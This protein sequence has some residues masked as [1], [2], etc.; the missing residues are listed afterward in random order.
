MAE[1]NNEMVEQ[2]K[3]EVSTREEK[4]VPGKFYSPATDI[5]ETED[6]LTVTMDMPGVKKD[7]V[8][9]S[10]ER[11]TL[12]VEGVIDLERYRKLRATYAEYNVGHFSRAF[13]LN[14]RVNRDKIEATMDNGVLTLTLPKVEEE[15][16]R[17][18][19]VG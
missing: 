3:K 6:A 11:D 7:N 17:M 2:Q 4:T 5:L 16:P 15:K 19:A 8:K 18:I 10:L 14:N 9:V 1:K 13:Q 12:N